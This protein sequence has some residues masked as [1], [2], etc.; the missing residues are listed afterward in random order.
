MERRKWTKE[1]IDQ[2]RT[3]HNSWFYFNKKDSNIMVPKVYGLG[4]TVNL[5][6]LYSWVFIAA[7]IVYIVFS[8]FSK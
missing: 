6:S 2:Y 7:F 4:W 8:V 1:E 5:A 3:T